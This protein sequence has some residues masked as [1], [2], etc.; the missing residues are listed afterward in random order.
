ME[1]SSYSRF[2]DIM[3]MEI[4]KK[5]SSEHQ[6]FSRFEI[7]DKPSRII[8]IGTLGDKSK[9]FSPTGDSRRTLTTVKNNSMSVKLLTKNT[10]GPIY[11][12]PSLSL[13]YRVYPTYEEEKAFIGR[14]HHEIIPEKVELA[15]IWR[16][17][18]CSFEPIKFDI[19]EN[20]IHQLDFKPFINAIENDE[21][22]CE[23]SKR[24]D[25][26]SLINQIA[27]VNQMQ[28]IDGKKS[29]LDW[30]GKIL[31]DVEEFFQDN[32]HLK[33]VTVTM[34]NETNES[35]YETFFFNC[36]LEMGVESINLEPFRYEYKYEGSTYHFTS[37]LR[38]LNCHADYNPTIG[39]ITSKHYAISEQKKISPREDISSITFPLE[40]LSSEDCLSLLEEIHEAM[41]IHL[42]SYKKTKKYV[43]NK[44]YKNKTDGFEKIADRFR[45]GIEILNN[46][47]I[48][49]KSF[50]LLNE[51]FRCTGK[52]KNWRIFQLVFIVSLIPDMVDK[53]K[54]RDICE[55]LHVDTGA[56][57][58]EAYLGCVVFSA[59]YD[60]LSGKEFGCTA[61]AKFPLRMLS[62]QQLQR[63]GRLFSWAEE[64][65]RKEGIVGEPFSV[66]YFVGSTEEFPRYTKPII[67]QLN[68]FKKKNEE[69][70]GK[71][72]EVCPICDGKIVLDYKDEERY[73]IHK[74]KKCKREFRLFYTDEEIY[75]FIPTLIV[76]T[77]DKLAAVAS[78]R[79]FKNILGG[80]ISKCPDG[81][82][83]IPPNDRC[84]VQLGH[85]EKCNRTGKL[86]K[87][88]FKTSPNLIIQDEMHLIRESFGT[89]N[90][91]FESL[92][93]NLQKEF[94]GFGP[95]YI[96]M[97]ATASGVKDQIKHL[98][99]K[100]VN[101]FPGE[102]PHGKGNNDFF[103]KFDLDE[104]KN[105]IQRVLIGLKPNLRDNQFAS[106]LTLKYLSKFIK[107]VETDLSRFS[108]EYEIP[109][110]DLKEII[111]N[112]KI[113]LTYHN[114]KSDVHSMN[115]YLEYAVNSEL[116]T[117]KIRPKILTGESTL[118]DIKSLIKEVK[119]FFEDPENRHTLL[120]VFA[121]SI[122]SHGVD[123]EKWNVM[124][125]QGITR[126][127]AEYIQAL[128]RVGRKYPGVV[129]VWFY[130]NRARDLSYYQHFPDYHDILERKVENV[131][132]S[133]WAKLGFKQT[134][135]SIF[136]A[137]I[138][139]YISEIL[140][141]P[142]YTVDKV[143]EVFS[144]KENRKRL[145]EFIK[146]AY[147]SDSKMIGA[148]FFE[149]RIPEETE[150]RLEMLAGYTGGKGNFFPNAL[151]DCDNKY[152]KTQFGMR[153]IQDTV[154]LKPIGYNLDFLIRA[155]EG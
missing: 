36:S 101:I 44:E 34:V 122:V 61:I 3:T 102:S 104:G 82:G 87:I 140:E 99:H 95:K 90:C 80:K 151:K 59:F 40:R 138:L 85:N 60:R 98:Y 119:R 71:I 25:S 106:L 118:E 84:E 133:R 123:I 142:V 81:H 37:Y 72:I 33:L 97:T 58:T 91:H 86:C 93:E 15:K 107:K 64:I 69:K 4:L 63:I 110:Q 155:K 113:F 16:R 121:T 53:S 11:V 141:E 8:I 10:Q 6:D 29:H 103:F 43:E 109:E 24:I 50:K 139:N 13:Y 55:V 21:N 153:G 19:S 128:S 5:L 144:Q 143:N 116:E 56:G 62:I 152:Y 154:V 49:L 137:S 100:E 149:A 92:I 108:R 51:T 88:D 38:C 42:K 114:K 17:Y 14:K 39:K 147:I 134:F 22:I 31:V 131:P 136:N 20:S 129:F 30:K 78:N 73:I 115:Y 130:P 41:L 89:I 26:S 66:A 146:K 18:E 125:F 94:C 111:E 148:S 67:D 120:S 9:D 127:T 135:T 2:I 7:P 105:V 1:S 126:S 150:E 77:V 96:A 47:E 76:S 83:F 57:K 54:R 132:L 35:K 12:K 27:Y 79:R 124:I 145:I 46:N 75:R 68:K 48:A 74:C 28:K 65:R 52:F 45:E 70:T 23:S 32:E 112:Y 117:Y